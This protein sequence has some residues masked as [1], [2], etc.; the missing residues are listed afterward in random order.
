MKDG[1]VMLVN[2]LENAAEKVKFI[3]LTHQQNSLRILKCQDLVLSLQAQ[4]DIRITNGFSNSKLSQT[5]VV[6][7]D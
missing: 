6:F 1:T 5:Q 2:Y 4:V 7:T 3:T